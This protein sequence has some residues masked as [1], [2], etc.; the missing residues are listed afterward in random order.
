MKKTAIIY[1]IFLLVSV[2]L[3]PAE[4]AGQKAAAAA[5]PVVIPD[6]AIRLRIL[7]NS[8]SEEDQAIK[9]LVRDRVND[10]INEWVADLTSF[11]EAR[12]V[13]RS[14][15]PEIRGIV[16]S[17]VEEN[18]PG[19]NFTVSFQ[20]NVKF[21]TKLY[22]NFIYPAG[23]YEAILISIGKAE[24]ANWW[25]VLF[26]PLCFLDFSN[27][28]AVKQEETAVNDG[29]ETERVE[30]KFFVVEWFKKAK[31]LFSQEPA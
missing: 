19:G 26:P 2:N 31:S 22:G 13:I 24:G 11:D 21:P 17:I 20:E 8:N 18:S 23:T 1:L 30:V 27:G 12:K 5:E 15:L 16:G 6:D 7:A 9:R 10:S 4:G 14:H 28:D 3:L 25:C 29:K